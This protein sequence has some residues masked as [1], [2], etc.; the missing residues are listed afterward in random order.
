MAEVVLVMGESGS[1]KSTSIRTLNPSETFIFNVLGKSLPFRGSNKN[2]T[3]YNKET[4][5]TGNLVRVTNSKNLL[6]W[7]D[8]VN[9]NLPNVKNII[10]E[11]NTHL[12]SLEFIG[13]IKEMGWDKFNDIAYNMVSIVN[14]CKNLRDDLVVFVIH[15]IKETGDGILEDKSYKAMT[16]G[17]LVDEKMS[18]YES[19]FTIVLLARAKNLDNDEI[20]YVFLTQDAKS[21][22]KSPMGMF[23]TKEIPNDLALV[24]HSIDCY[25]NDE[26]C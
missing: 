18:S 23:N 16:L 21:T 15:H 6:K 4:N 3:P 13:R 1:G 12:S 9:E 19:F 11:D 25:L 22:A 20:E 26:N 14:K 17:K 5:P 7:L 10:I 2:Y 24:R 8:Y